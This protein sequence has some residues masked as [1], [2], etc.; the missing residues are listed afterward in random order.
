M[1]DDRIDLQL[2]D[3]VKKGDSKAFDMLVM[4][5]QTRVCKIVSRFVKDPHEMMDVSQEVFI[6]AYKA[7]DKFRADSSF[8]TW[9][10][11][12]AINASK[13]YLV[14]RG[15]RLPDI[16]FEI[17]DMERYSGRNGRCET[18]T[19]ES[20]V[21]RDEIENLVYDA[22]D[23]LPKDLRMAILLREMDG[24]TY[25]QIADAMDCPVG[26]VRSRIFRAR[27]VID[28]MVQPLIRQ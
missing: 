21:M 27:A 4:R 28:K 3:A 14:E 16:T 25:G 6:K 23:E 24:L 10:Y 20:L 1:Y 5:Y 8:Y 26:T 22:I 12:I 17:V 15:H 11:R 19:P 7:L 2:I 18:N 13:N 9:L